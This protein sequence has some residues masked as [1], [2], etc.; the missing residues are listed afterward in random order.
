M[1]EAKPAG[2]GG[3]AT[4]GLDVEVPAGDWLVGVDEIA[5]LGGCRHSRSG[6]FDADRLTRRRQARESPGQIRD[7]AVALRALCFECLNPPARFLVDDSRY[8]RSEVAI[9]AFVRSQRTV[10]RS[11]TGVRS[12]DD[13]NSQKLG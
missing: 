7:L 9:P 4:A 10:I 5:D 3:I 11:E 1:S 8:E 12:N 13:Q 6:S 2:G